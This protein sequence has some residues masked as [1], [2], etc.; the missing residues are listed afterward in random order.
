MKRFALIGAAG[1]IA[2]R[3]LKAI[4][5]TGNTLVAA[6]DK[7]DNVGVLDSYFPDTN[8]FTEFERFD[9]HLD[10][11]KRK[12]EPVEIISICSPNYLHDSHIR[13][14]LRYG[15]D[16]ICEKP[17]VLSPWNVDALAEI[18]QETGRRIY[19][20]LQLR[21]HPSIIALREQ[22]RQAPKDKVYDI[23]LQYIT[24][25]GNWY[26][27]SWKGDLSKS[28]GIATNIGVHFFDMLIWIFGAVK[29]VQ[30]SRMTTDAAAGYLELQQARV[31]WMLSINA[32]DLPA[33]VKASGKRTFRSLTLEGKEIEFSE[34]F[35]DLHTAS[36]ADIIA[37]NGFGLED[38]RAAIEVTHQIRNFSAAAP[39]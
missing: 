10:K 36:Y 22:V 23:D 25:R 24:S 28:G 34:G 33:D 1:F 6:L 35:T 31:H 14:A 5:D 2:P 11:L 39:L 8:F 37:G 29:D 19:T 38:A 32:N 27:A 30:V 9:R 16:A 17:L 3:H 21:L 26:H 20:I 18:Q 12:G 7:H 13:Y 4:K 15:A